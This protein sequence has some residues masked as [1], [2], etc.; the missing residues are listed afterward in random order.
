M[1]EVYGE[2]TYRITNMVLQSQADW[3]AIERFEKGE[4]I[5]QRKAPIAL[6]NEQVLAWLVEAALRYVTARRCRSRRCSRWPY[7][8]RSCS[9]SQLDMWFPEVRLLKVRSEE[10]SNQLVGLRAVD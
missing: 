10:M 3:G 7:S 2:R 4:R 8:T 9:V 6:S 1:S 5:K